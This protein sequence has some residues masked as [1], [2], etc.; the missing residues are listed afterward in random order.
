MN[1][2]SGLLY[3]LI[4]FLIDYNFFALLYY[5]FH[6]KSPPNLRRSSSQRLDDDVRNENKL[7]NKMSTKNIN[8]SNLVLKNVTKVFK[9]MTAVN[10][11]CLN[12][13]KHEC[14]GL[15]GVNGAGKTTTFKMMTGDELITSGD[16]WI[17]GKCLKTQLLDAHKF[18]GYCPQ[19]DNC[20]PELTGRETLKI[21]ALIRGIKMDEINELVN[22]MSSELDFKQHLDKQ[23]RAYSGGNRRKLSTALALLGNPE[24]IFLDVSSIPT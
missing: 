17:K 11:L 18:I 2:G 7:V 6:K 8:S 24:L 20:L 22:Q 15:L 23:V 10:Q 12:I 19:F 1:I 21:F 14:F 4:V 16:I 9:K 13:K 3:L 5:K